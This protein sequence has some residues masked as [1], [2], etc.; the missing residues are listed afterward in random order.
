MHKVKVHWTQTPA[1]K[2]RMAQIVRER[3][4]ANGHNVTETAP[5]PTSVQDAL[6]NVTDALR[7]S[8]DQ[9]KAAEASLREAVTNFQAVQEQLTKIAETIAG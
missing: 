9:F 1:G 8:T 2:V 7:T 4:R 5:A 3:H 6:E